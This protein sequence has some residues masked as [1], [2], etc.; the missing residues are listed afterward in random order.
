[1]KL[2]NTE[3]FLNFCCEMGRHLIQSGAEIYRVEDSINHLMEAY[4]YTDTEVFAIPAS[5]IF[6]ILEDG[7]N[8]TKAIRIRSS[9]INLDKLERLNSLCRQVCRETPSPAEALVR[10]RS[11]TGLSVS[12]FIRDI[13]MKEACLIAHKDPNIR[14]SELAYRVGYK[15]PKYFATSFKKDIGM[16]PTEYLEEVKKQLSEGVTNSLS[17]KPND[18]KPLKELI[19]D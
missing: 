13:R 18:F 19:E 17:N 4:G 7:H 8:Y 11:I 1:M 12:S 9:F 2:K 3:E 10:L 14:I 15:D 6:N 16:Q 5:V